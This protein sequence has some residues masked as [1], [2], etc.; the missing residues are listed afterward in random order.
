MLELP[1]EGWMMLGLTV[2]FLI[3]FVGTG[4]VPLPFTA[5]VLWLSQFHFPEM[6]I[7]VATL[8]TVIGWVCFEGMLRR[9]LF[10]HPEVTRHIPVAYQKFFL[11]RTGFWLFIF[12]AFPFPWDFMRFLALLN[13][14]N[15]TRLLVIL[16]VS[17]LVRNTFLVFLGTALA[18]HQ[19][20]L[21]SVMLAFLLLPLALNKLFQYLP[22]PQLD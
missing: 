20:L 10:R 4:P 14:Y 22:K 9:W 12:N 16:A 19:P 7:L 11:R 2:L 18:P 8:G 1:P 13:N 21:W 17:R 15:R 5:T 6:V 3:C